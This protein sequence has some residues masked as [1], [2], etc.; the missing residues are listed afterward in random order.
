MKSVFTLNIMLLISLF[1]FGQGHIKLVT[2]YTGDV[3]KIPGL[4]T[5][6]QEF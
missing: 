4:N 3:R 5:T 2:N 1:S 6:Q